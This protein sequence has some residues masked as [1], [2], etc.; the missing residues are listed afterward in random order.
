M[1]LLS[2]AGIP[3]FADMVEDWNGGSHR[4]AVTFDDGFQNFVDNAFPEI[5]GRKIPATLFVVTGY[6]GEEAGWIKDRGH[7]NYREVLISPEV[8][9]A[10]PEALVRIGSHSVTHPRLSSMDKGR[11]LAELI[12]SRKYLEALL[13]REITTLAFP[14]DDYSDVIIELAQQAGYRH[15]FKDLPTC[16]MTISNSF[17][18]GRISVSPEDWGIEYYLKIKGA[19]QWLP[20]AVR[21]KNLFRTE[22]RRPKNHK[23]QMRNPI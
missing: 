16:P 4:I 22:S 15:V 20:F 19:Y 9:K 12:D 14:Y 13:E 10:L 23:A 3:V 2:R 5:A 21:I 1:D 6:L 8:L 11:A 18:L 7:V 17:L